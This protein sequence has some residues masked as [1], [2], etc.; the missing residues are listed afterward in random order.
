V[1]QKKDK[2]YVD[3]IEN[4]ATELV[5]RGLKGTRLHLLGPATVYE[6]DKLQAMLLVMDDLEKAVGILERRGHDF[7]RF[8]AKMSPAGLPSFRVVFGGQEHWLHTSAEVDEFRQA[9]AKETGRELVVGDEAAQKASGQTNGHTEAPLPTFFVHELHE[10]RGINKG[11][12]K[13]KEFGLTGADLIPLP[14]I[15]GREPPL[16]YKLEN[17]D[18]LHPLLHLRDLTADV[19][20]LGEKGLTITRFKGLGEMDPSEL[21]ETTLDPKVRTLLQVHL[22][23]ALKADEMFRI[24]M[25]EKVEPRRDFI[26]KHALE[27]KDIDYHGA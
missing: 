19:R 9:K 4:M 5:K 24:L 6:G 7:G 2:R 18:M 12:E 21:W 1:T 23:D 3:T 10:V 14:R 27:V 22:E 16:R 25:G 8:L 17:G 15:A 11:L 13:L 26:V 20:K